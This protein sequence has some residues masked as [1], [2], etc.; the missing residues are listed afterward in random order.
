M[1]ISGTGVENDPYIVDTWDDFVTAITSGTGS[2]GV[3]VQVDTSSVTTWNFPQEEPTGITTAINWN[4]ADV[5][6]QGLTIKGM[7]GSAAQW[8]QNSSSSYVKSIRNINFLDMAKTQ[9]TTGVFSGQ[10][11]EFRNCQ[12]SG[13]IES[14]AFL[15]QSGGSNYFATGSISGS[16]PK[17]CAIAFKFSG[18]G[19]ITT[20]SGG[21][22]AA[23]FQHCILNLDGTST[24]T[25]YVKMS[26]CKIIGGMP[27]ANFNNSGGGQN[28]I[29]AEV[30]S[31][32]TWTNSGGGV[33]LLNTDKLATGLSVPSNY[34]GVTSAQ[35]L[36]VDALAAVGFT[37]VE[38]EPEEEEQQGGE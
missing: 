4:A 1:S 15:A 23:V 18:N 13:T 24:A 2:A 31:I 28:V 14:G 25:P 38:E 34:T 16:D 5:D 32:G 20:A 8:F 19:N 33:T 35:M 27:W 37:A 21:S 29:D 36:D 9:A 11:Y 6:G 10:K 12:L 22:S 7:F 26:E 30:E 3:Y 17:G